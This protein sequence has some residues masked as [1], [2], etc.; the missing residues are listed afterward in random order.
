MQDRQMEDALD[1]QRR[2]EV[3]RF[4]QRYIRYR[5]ASG[6]EVAAN[7]Y[8]TND[9]RVYDANGY[10]IEGA[11]PADNRGNALPPISS[12]VGGQAQEPA[13]PAVQ[14]QVDAYRKSN[15]VPYPGAPLADGQTMGGQYPEFVRGR[16]YSAG[17][18]F[19]HNKKVYVVG[20]DGK[21]HEMVGGEEPTIATQE[22][23][24]PNLRNVR[25][26]E[27]EIADENTGYDPYLAARAEQRN[28]QSVAEETEEEA[29]R[30]HEQ[31]L[32]RDMRRAQ[33]R[34]LRRQ[35]QAKADAARAEEA[36]KPGNAPLSQTRLV[37]VPVAVW[38]KLKR[39][40]GEAAMAAGENIVRGGDYIGG[41]IAEG[42]DAVSDGIG[43][44][45]Q[46]IREQGRDMANITPAEIFSNAGKE[47]SGYKA[48]LKSI[49][50]MGREKAIPVIRQMLE[51]NG[52]DA[53][54]VTTDS[55]AGNAV[56]NNILKLTSPAHAFNDAQKRGKK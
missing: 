25:P 52:V 4:P 19:M 7:G 1:A 41:K 40:V 43:K 31:Q 34:Q 27:D 24:P 15:E 55:E 29:L 33:Y 53:S 23:T 22:P 18:K 54:D 11:R 36:K 13:D 56:F 38:R 16:K 8:V 51:D 9:G 48:A 30:R 14:A 26:A 50:A 3:T 42:I 2:S 12:L 35:S 20:A 46:D 28:A 37:D 39:G 47:L 5:D 44:M 32:D 45:V 17:E 6:R 10:E 21:P 49:V